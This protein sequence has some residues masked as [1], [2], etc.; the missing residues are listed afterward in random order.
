MISTPRL[1][2]RFRKQDLLC[3][4][5]L[6][7][8][9]LIDRMAPG[10]S[11]SVL[12]GA[13]LVSR[14]VAQGHLCLDLPDW[15][16]P[17][18]GP[19]RAE[20]PPLDA[21]REAFLAASPAICRSDGIDPV[22][23]VFDPDANRLYLRRYWQYEQ[24]VARGLRDR[25]ASV[26]D[27]PTTVASL[28]EV[29][30]QLFPGEESDD[31]QRLAAF[32][33]LTRRLCVITGGPGTGKTHTVARILALLLGAE[34]AG[35]HVRLAAPTGKAAAR[36]T[37]SIRRVRA[38]LPIPEA[39]RRAI[40]EEAQTIHRLLGAV[41]GSP[42]FRHNR[43]NPLGADVVILDEASMVDLP[44][45]AKLLQALRPATRLILLGDMHQLA[46]V[47]PGFVLGDLCRA[48]AMDRFSTGVRD[49]FAD[50]AGQPATDAELEW[51][52]DA[53]M[54][55]SVVRLAHSHRFA[56]GGGVASLC[57]RLPRTSGEEA[58][59]HLE[60][61][62][63]EQKGVRW[64]DAVPL[65]GE[66]AP[67]RSLSKAIVEGYGPLLAAST[68]EEAFDAL[69]RFR[70]L[71]PTRRGVLGV[72]WLNEWTERILEAE[73]PTRLRAS[74]RFYDHR[75]VLIRRND[76][77]LRLFNGDVGI[78][79]ADP[80]RDGQMT[81][82]F[83]GS[84]PD[85]PGGWRRIPPAMLPEHETAFAMTIHKSQG[86][87]YDRVLL[88]LPAEDRPILTREL[89]YTAVSRAREAVEIHAPREVLKT[90]IDRQVERTSGL[91]EALRDA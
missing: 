19:D 61:V 21:W 43:E 42:Y 62:T 13:A 15:A 37:E 26:D 6:H 36:M 52:P 59:M 9:D 55:D 46:S 8:A 14:E 40:P 16:R 78:L 79:L 81:A 41:P 20:F 48:V 73:G 38:D 80:D 57:E 60:T 35:V 47:E 69:D 1:L 85:R 12:L 68:P 44:L 11:E 28:P 29:F 25:S 71:T 91:Q 74:G 56:S 4:V 32:T 87:E 64:I 72:E 51:C 88:A 75:P 65:S 82:W 49:A 7:L 86:S 54:A 22:P 31:R 39:I 50:L 77:S 83:P 76:Y 90:A 27:S 17:G 3:E 89:V 10:T 66:G 63:A 33:A 58:L 2:E 67:S 30:A 24:A 84:A 53:G 34:P 23:L 18:D 70:I 45:M 5:D